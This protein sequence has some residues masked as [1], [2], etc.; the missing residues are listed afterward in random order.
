VLA[1]T[2]LLCEEW[3]KSTPLLAI[4]K[5]NLSWEGLHANVWTL[6]WIRPE[7]QGT[8]LRPDL[9]WDTKTSPHPSTFTC[10]SVPSTG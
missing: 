8:A 1:G 10:F 2:F 9:S 5:V 6:R 4:E 7:K 3:D